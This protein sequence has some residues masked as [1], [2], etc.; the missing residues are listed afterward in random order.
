LSIARCEV[1]TCDTKDGADVL[2]AGHNALLIRRQHHPWRVE[3]TPAA[4]LDVS[5]LHA[6]AQ[7]NDP[8]PVYEQSRSQQPMRCFRLG[9]RIMAEAEGGSKRERADC[10]QEPMSKGDSSCAAPDERDKST[11]KGRGGSAP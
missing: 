3:S 7:A 9:R 8:I 5:R 1:V 11:L 10:E 6:T 4:Q 2:L